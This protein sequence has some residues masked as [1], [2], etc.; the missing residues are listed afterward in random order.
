MN[1][2]WD[3]TGA[4]S[5]GYAQPAPLVA[6]SELNLATSLLRKE[7][8]R[9]PRLSEPEMVRHYTNLSRRNFGIDTGF[10]PLGSCTMKH[11]PRVNEV[12]AQ[13][14]GIC[15]VHPHQPEHHLQ[16][17]LAIFHEMQHMLAV[18]AGMDEVTLQPVA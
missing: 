4:A 6:E 9:W 3:H 1:N 10:Y 5:A 17:L 8:P 2:L 16:G 11:N 15:D 12:I 18:C 7:A 14:P 13:M